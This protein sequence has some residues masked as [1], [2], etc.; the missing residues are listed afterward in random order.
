[1]FRDQKYTP[2][3]QLS[4]ADGKVLVLLKVTLIETIDNVKSGITV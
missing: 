1:M 4:L 2:V 3:T